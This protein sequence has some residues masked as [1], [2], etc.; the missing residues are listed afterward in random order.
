MY[1]EMLCIA[2]VLLVMLSASASDIRRREVSD[3]HWFVISAIGA[4]YGIRLG[5]T[6]WLLFVVGFVMILSSVYSPRLD[7]IR[8]VTVLILSVPVMSMSYLA[9]GD[10]MPV[11][12]AAMSILAVAMYYSGVMTGGADVKALIALSMAFP[13][14]PDAGCILWEPTF[15]QSMVL[16]P[17][18]SS[19]VIG[20]L[21]S[22]LLTLPTV[23]RNLITGQRPIQSFPMG[24]GEARGSFVWP[25]EDVVDGKRAII[26]PS[27]NT[28]EV[29]RRLQDAGIEEI[30][31]AWMI[32]FIVPLTAGLI[33]TILLGCPLFAVI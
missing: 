9:S 32:P 17:V 16:N 28:E 31:V 15:P 12:A 10:V 18:M 25:L 29:Y 14:Y 7:G 27:D 30:R 22:V 19:L 23:V 8:S 33:I 26:G 21:I 6:G 20:L 1:A 13:I 24:V 3:I 2:A 11:I 4:I 5:L